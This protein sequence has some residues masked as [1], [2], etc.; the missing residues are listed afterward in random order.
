MRKKF[1][2]LLAFAMIFIFTGYTYENNISK[3]S[4]EDFILSFV[5][6]PMLLAISDY[7]GKPRMFD[8]Y[9]AKILEMKPLEEGK[10]FTSQ[11]KVQ[12]KTYI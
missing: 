7:Y 2:I 6:Q 11:I 3:K 10:R 12:V 8:L 5:S 9:D 4:Q 1:L